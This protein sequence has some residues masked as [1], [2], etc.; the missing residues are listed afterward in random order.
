METAVSANLPEPEK[1]GTSKAL[2]VGTSDINSSR[3]SGVTMG[4]PVDE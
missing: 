2:A 4:K 1:R 3:L